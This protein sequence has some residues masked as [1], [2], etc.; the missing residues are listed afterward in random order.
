MPTKRNAFSVEEWLCMTQ[1][2]PTKQTVTAFALKP[3]DELTDA[4]N[5][6][7]AAAQRDGFIVTTGCKGDLAVT[8]IFWRDRRAQALPYAELSVRRNRASFIGFF[9]TVALSQPLA[10]FDAGEWLAVVLERFS[11]DEGFLVVGVE[12]PTADL[13]LPEAYGQALRLT[14]LLSEA[15]RIARAEKN[16]KTA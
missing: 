2:M 16:Q 9:D 1:S 13:R 5:R 15:A 11:L 14:G 6:R 7:L 4:Q 3:P 8:D 10:S 12:V